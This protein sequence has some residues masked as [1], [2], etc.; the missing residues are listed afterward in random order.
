MKIIPQTG[1]IQTPLKLAQIKPYWTKRYNI[2]HH[3]NRSSLVR[4]NNGS[5]N[6]DFSEVNQAINDKM[7][8]IKQLQKKIREV[9]QRL[10]T[11]Y[12]IDAIVSLENQLGSI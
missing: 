8:K 1:L 5:H 11:C 10:R 3:Q 9:N 2:N 7:K 6:A 4:Q 12:D